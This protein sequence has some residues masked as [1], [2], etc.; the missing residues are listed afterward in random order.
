MLNTTES[1]S[2]YLARKSQVESIRSIFYEYDRLTSLKRE[3]A[4]LVTRDNAASEGAVVLLI[5]PPGSGKTQLISDFASDYPVEP[6]ALVNQT[7]HEFADRVPV[8]TVQVPDTG[9]KKLTENT[10][11]ALSGLNPAGE[12]RADIQ[13]DIKHHAKEMETRLFIFEEVHQATQDKKHET[14]K[15]VARYFKDLSNTAAFSLLLVGT[16]EAKRVIEASKE[17]ERRV[18]ATYELTGFDWNDRA[19]RKDFLGIL[20]EMD[21]RF[22]GVLGRNS[23]LTNPDNAVR[24]PPASDGVIGLAARLIERAGVLALREMGGQVEFAV[25][26]RHLARAFDDQLIVKGG[27]NPFTADMEAVL[28]PEE[29]AFPPVRKSSRNAGRDRNMRP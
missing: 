14:V 20:D 23:G 7:E 19:Q 18:I 8:A 28:A 11:M 13:D 9:L 1:T 4:D 25:T 16:E 21:N 27:F 22:A 6:R 26:V 2:T 3:F 10:L 15:R 5:G 29:A 24:K 17:L 12:R